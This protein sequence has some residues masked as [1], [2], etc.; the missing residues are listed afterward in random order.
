MHKRACKNKDF[1]NLIIPSE[2]TKIL[3]YKQYEKFDKAPVFLYS[4]LEC[5]IEKIDGWK[6]NPENSSKTK[7]SEHI[8]PGFS[9]ATIYPFR[10]RKRG[11]DCLK[12]FYEFLREHAMK[13]TN[14]KKKEGN[15]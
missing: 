2:N 5:V 14:F 4:D 8:P 10:R 15:Y 13:I 12:K 3:E 7:V 9:M 6:N 1:Y 11:I